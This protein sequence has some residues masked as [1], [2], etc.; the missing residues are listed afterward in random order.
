[1]WDNVVG[2]EAQKQYLQRYLKAQERP[3]ALL[4]SG[5]DGLGKRQLALEFAKTLL[6]ATHTGTDNCKACRLMNLADD[7][8]S[9]PDFSW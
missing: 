5:P 2:H 3:H 7:S 8:L 4:F 6:C 9:H 1:M